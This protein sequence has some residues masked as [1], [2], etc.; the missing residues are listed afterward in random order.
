MSRIEEKCEQQLDLKIV[1]KDTPEIQGHIAATLAWLAASIRYSEI[2]ELS[3]SYSSIVLTSVNQGPLFQI[4]ALPL[5]PVK[6]ETSCWHQL[7]VSMVV[8]T[9]YPVRERHRGKGL[10][11]DYRLM[12]ALAR[13]SLITEWDRGLVNRGLQFTLVPVELLGHKI[14][15]P[16]SRQGVQWH[17]LQNSDL[18]K[19]ENE[20]SR[21]IRQ[22]NFTGRGR[23]KVNDPSVFERL[24]TKRIFLGWWNKIQINIGTEHPRTAV[25]KSSAKAA[26]RPKT[27]KVI[28]ASL[29]GGGQGATG[30]LNVAVGIGD[31]NVRAQLA[32]CDRIEKKLDEFKTKNLVLYDTDT[33]RAWMLPYIAVVLYLVH[34]RE[35]GLENPGPG[36]VPPYAL[37][38]PAS[39]TEPRFACEAAYHAV[40]PIIAILKDHEQGTNPVQ[41]GP[42]LNAEKSAKV[43][44]AQAERLR[45]HLEQLFL[46][47]Y[48]AQEKA[49]QTRDQDMDIIHRTIYG[50]E[51]GHLAQGTALF[52]QQ[53]LQ[54][55][56]GGWSILRRDAGVLF[57]SGIGDAISP[58]LSSS[59]SLCEKWREVP[60]GKDYLVAPI[61]CLSNSEEVHHLQPPPGAGKTPTPKRPDYFTILDSRQRKER[62]LSDTQFQPCQGTEEHHTKYCQRTVRMRS[63][64]HGRGS[65]KG[66]KDF[67]EYMDGAVVFGRAERRTKVR[68]VLSAAWKSVQGRNREAKPQT[69]PIAAPRTEGASFDLPG[70]T[71]SVRLGKNSYE[72]DVPI[73]NVPPLHLVHDVPGIEA[74]H[75]LDEH[76]A[77]KRPFET[78]TIARITPPH[79]GPPTIPGSPEQPSRAELNVPSTNTSPTSRWRSSASDTN[80]RGTSSMTSNPGDPPDGL[81]KETPDCVEKSLQHM[82][83]WAN[84]LR[85]G[86]AA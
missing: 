1:V 51:L 49:K 17:L 61:Y 65:K 67:T 33:R 6:D 20:I 79:R 15:D 86:V 16:A 24:A 56:S 62:K 55:T 73:N 2:R 41:H 21:R 35:K 44:L 13:T 71:S 18:D 7:F 38:L 83:E 75:L 22:P 27:V 43:K 45:N 54:Y 76:A 26:R 39:M 9:G 4:R 66:I 70:N 32:L 34:V 77:T 40:K 57:C 48:E 23:W 30:G 78:S 84:G 12:T 50:P 37:V 80:T 28:G 46:R 11:I 53:R 52:R 63:R 81:G 59:E 60:K 5:K 82:G 68:S 10:E 36:M 25:I 72:V 74:T 8:A 85:D 64:W 3:R 31:R 29:N 47:L 19:P 69:V 42:V 14:G 58:V